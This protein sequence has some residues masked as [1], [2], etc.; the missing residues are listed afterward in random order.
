MG[1]SKRGTQ[2]R[3][4]ARTPAANRAAVL[5]LLVL[6]AGAL[7]ACGDDSPVKP[8]PPPGPP[9]PE[10]L[11][12]RE[13]VLQRLEEVYI[14]RDIVGYSNLLDP[15]DYLFRFTDT[16]GGTPVPG[17]MNRDQDLLITQRMLTEKG[18]SREI[19]SLAIKVQWK[20][21]QWTELKPDTAAG[22]LE[23]WWET[24]VAYTFTI[25]LAGDVTLITFGLPRSQFTVRQRSD[26]RWSLV[27]WTDLGSAK[28]LRALRSGGTVEETSWGAVKAFYR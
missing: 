11:T 10:S 24:T 25:V 12:K 3:A 6:L 5:A 19:V 21:A 4:A 17:K 28:A 1:I 23:S 14:N 20:N 13:H 18:T 9:G 16:S 27:R 22:R 15:D 7:V 2:P 26:G 8:P